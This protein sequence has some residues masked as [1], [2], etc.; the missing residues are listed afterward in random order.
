MWDGLPAEAH[1]SWA[2]EL[3]IF[4]QSKTNVSVDEQVLPDH[5]LDSFPY[6]AVHSEVC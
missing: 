3:P 1:F 2:R 6:V 4:D 5:V